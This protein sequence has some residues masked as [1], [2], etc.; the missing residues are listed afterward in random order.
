M[1]KDLFDKYVKM[2]KGC[3]MVLFGDN[4]MFF[5]VNVEGSYFTQTEDAVHCF[6]INVTADGL[7]MMSQAEAPY[8]V[9]VFQYEQIQYIR[10]FPDPKTLVGFLDDTTPAV[11][12]ETIEGIKKSMLTSPIMQA[13]APHGPN[14]SAVSNGYTGAVV[15]MDREADPYIRK[16][17]EEFNKEHNQQP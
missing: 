9:I 16:A 5:N 13:S 17:M 2:A 7:R 10:I 3:P 1:T 14:G 8:E 12:G 15:S 4:S 6:R 11:E